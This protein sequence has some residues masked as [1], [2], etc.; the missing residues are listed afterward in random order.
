MCADQKALTG[1]MDPV[2]LRK[3]NIEPDDESSSGE[4]IQDSYSGMGNSEKAAMS[5]YGLKIT[6]F[7]RK[8]RQAYRPGKQGPHWFL[9]DKFEISDIDVNTSIP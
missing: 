4:S 1:Q 3:V 9:T 2:E 8:L 5:R 7:H 6:R